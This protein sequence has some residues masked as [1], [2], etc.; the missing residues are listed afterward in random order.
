MCN[1]CNSCGRNRG[2]RNNSCGCS[3]LI[4][5]LANLFSTEFWGNGNNNCSC[6]YARGFVSGV[7]AVTNNDNGNGC[8]CGCSNRNS[9]GWNNLFAVNS[10]N[11]NGSNGGCG[12]GCGC[13]SNS[14]NY[15][16]QQYALG[17]Y[18][19]GRSCCCGSGFNF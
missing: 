5:G 17:P 19:N 7:N 4:D 16:A 15:Y 3:G 12:C 2:G 10:F 13:N 8:G 6:A 1:S 18:S 11:S 9:N 14:D